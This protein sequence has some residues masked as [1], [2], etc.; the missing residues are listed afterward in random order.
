ML[1]VAKIGKSKIFKI[2]QGTVDLQSNYH[3]FVG[4]SQSDLCGVTKADDGNADLSIIDTELISDVSD[5]AE[6]VVLE[7]I[8]CH[9]TCCVYQEQYVS[10]LSAS[11]NFVSWNKNKIPCQTHDTVHSG[12]AYSLR[13]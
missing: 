8:V 7:I 5:E 11:W 4:R 9:V 1:N 3:R 12:G 10:L 6:H 13:P 2:K